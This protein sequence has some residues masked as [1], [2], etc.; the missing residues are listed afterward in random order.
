MCFGDWSFFIRRWTQMD[1]DY[2]DGDRRG[3]AQMGDRFVGMDWASDQSLLNLDDDDE[4]GAAATIRKFR[5]VRF[6]SGR[7]RGA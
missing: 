2:R 3:L 7:E 1:A 4:I 5:I 6:E